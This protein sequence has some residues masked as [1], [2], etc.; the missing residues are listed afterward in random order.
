ME[1]WRAG[2]MH[3]TSDKQCNKITFFGKQINTNKMTFVK[4]TQEGK[5]IMLF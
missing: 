2:D 1:Y 4:Q 5:L 3:T